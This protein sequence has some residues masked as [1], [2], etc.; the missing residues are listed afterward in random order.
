MVERGCG[1]TSPERICL[2]MPYRE[3]ATAA[4]CLVSPVS[5]AEIRVGLCEKMRGSSRR[6]VS[7]LPSCSVLS[8]R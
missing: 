5:D 4:L 3:P 1:T 6:C 8:L 2:A 7:V